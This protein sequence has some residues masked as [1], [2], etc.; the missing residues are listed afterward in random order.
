MEIGYEIRCCSP[1]AFDLKYCTLLGAGV[2]KLFDEG[3]TGCIVVAK[4]DGTIKPLYLKDVEDESG[5]IKPRLVD[6]DSEDFKMVYSNMHFIKEKNYEEAKKYIPNPE[7]YN[8]NN[9]L[10]WN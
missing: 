10:K 2:K 5:K 3:K 8:I 9:I 4:N 7:D 6:I 1:V